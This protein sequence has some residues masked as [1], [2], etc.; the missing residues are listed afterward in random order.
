[1]WV[2]LFVGIVV[3]DSL[4]FVSG[5]ECHEDLLGCEEIERLPVLGFLGSGRL[6]NAFFV[7]SNNQEYA[8][9][10]ALKSGLFISFHFTSFEQ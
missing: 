9:R 10:F 6:K 7:S 2:I 1:M 4:S 8:I 5:N 3:F